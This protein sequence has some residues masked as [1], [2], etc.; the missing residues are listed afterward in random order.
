MKGFGKKL[1]K[2]FT[3]EKSTGRTRLNPNLLQEIKASLCPMA[4]E[5]IDQENEALRTVRQN[6]KDA[7]K[8][9]KEA[10]TLAVERAKVSQ[11]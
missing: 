8:Q 5:V 1:H 3:K 10:E 7:E 4:Q 2:L 6:L 11:E 9:L